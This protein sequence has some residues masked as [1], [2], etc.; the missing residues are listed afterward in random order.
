MADAPV[1][2]VGDIDRGGVFAALLGTLSLLDPDDRARVGGLIVNRFRGDATVLTPGLPSSARAP[3]CRCSASCPISKRGSCPPRTRSIWTSRRAGARPARSTS[4][5]SACRSSRTSTTSSRSRRARRS[6]ALRARRRRD[7][8][9]RRHRVA[10]QQGHRRRPAVA[11]RHRAGAV[12]PARGGGRAADRRR[13]RGL[14][15]A[16]RSRA[17]PGSRRVRRALDARPRIVAGRHDI[18][19]QQDDRPCSSSG[20]RTSG[21]FAGAAGSEVVAYEIHAGRTSASSPTPFTIVERGDRAVHDADGAVSAAGN[22]VGTYLHGLFANDSLRR[23]FLRS[24]AAREGDR[25]RSTVGHA[26]R[27]PIRA[28]RRCRVRARWTSEPWPSSWGSHFPGPE[29]GSREA[30]RSAPGSR[31]RSGLRRSAQPLPSRRVARPAPRRGPG[32]S[33]PA[34]RR[35]RSSSG[36]AALTLGVAGL[37]S[38]A[39]MAV[40]AL[41]ARLGFAGLVVEAL[42]LTCLLSVRGLAGAAREVAGARP[43]RSRRRSPSG[44]ISPG[45]PPHRGARRGHVASATIESVAENLTD[46]LVAPALWFLAGGLAGAAVYRAIN[47]ADAMFGYRVGPLEYFGKVAARLDDL[48]NLIPARLAGLSVVAAAALAGES[49]SGALAALR[50]DRRRTA[51]PNAGLDHVRDG[52]RARRAPRSPGRTGS[53]PARCRPPSTSSVP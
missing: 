16:R 20:G 23:A 33:V 42:A 37:A 17:R 36:G 22:V 26:G 32:P 28:P 4:R 8:R 13:V 53:A 1:L 25:G 48:L 51:S 41:A 43:R 27:R 11:H 18:R 49:A 31:D 40:A 52:G 15:D 12:D 7:P 29:P 34:A 14:P 30:S 5:S 6:R 2:L 39:A 9:R 50:R 24:L 10:G 3:G 35:R 47:T 21:P 44:R 46:S 19:A 38:V 45:E